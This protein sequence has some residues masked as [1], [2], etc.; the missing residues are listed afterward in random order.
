M[1]NNS[2]SVEKLLRK[3]KKVKESKEIEKS[4]IRV[5]NRFL[6]LKEA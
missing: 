5:K 6:D 2:T 3:C 1:G 4:A